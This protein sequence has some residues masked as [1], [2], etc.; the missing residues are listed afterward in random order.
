[1]KGFAGACQEGK[2]KPRPFL[3]RAGSSS[4]VDQKIVIDN[5]LGEGPPVPVTY[6]NFMAVS[7]G[8]S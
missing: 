2:L 6:M 8:G 4:I 1:M 3:P 5:G 7:H